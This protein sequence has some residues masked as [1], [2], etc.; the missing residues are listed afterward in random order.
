MSITKKVGFFG[1]FLRKIKRKNASELFKSGFLVEA[2]G[3]QGLQA[4]T[5]SSDGEPLSRG[6]GLGVT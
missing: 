2:E 6:E 5:P 1:V 3:R 4:R